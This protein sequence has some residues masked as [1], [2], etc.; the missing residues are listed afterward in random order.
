M[1]SLKINDGGPAFA[2]AAGP[3]GLSQSQNGM[4]LRDY[5]AG[6][7]VIGLIGGRNWS[8]VKGGDDAVIK[9]WAVSAYLVADAMIA[10]RSK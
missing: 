6:Q 9:Q 4:S 3:H 8:E 1:M 10:A 5:L 7:A 2:R